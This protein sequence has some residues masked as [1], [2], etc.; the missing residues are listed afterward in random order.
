MK[1]VKEIQA[2]GPFLVRNYCTASASVHSA[3]FPGS[4]QHLHDQRA[5]KSHQFP[6]KLLPDGTNPYTTYIPV[7]SRS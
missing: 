4:S 3:C 2:R 5:T 1:H 7:S 6:G